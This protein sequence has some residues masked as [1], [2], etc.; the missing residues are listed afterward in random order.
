MQSIRITS[1]PHSRKSQQNQLSQF[2]KT[3]TKVIPIEK[4]EA[5]DDFDDEPRVQPTVRHIRFCSLSK[6]S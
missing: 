3:S 2:R 5:G 6:N 4:T 1:R